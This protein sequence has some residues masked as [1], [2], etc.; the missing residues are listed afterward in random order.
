MGQLQCLSAEG[1]RDIESAAV[2]S[3]G[4][5]TQVVAAGQ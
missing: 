5:S 1:V 3:A 2:N 4:E